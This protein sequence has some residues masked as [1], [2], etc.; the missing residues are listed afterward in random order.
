ELAKILVVM[1][2]EFRNSKSLGGQSPT[3]DGIWPI[4]SL[5]C[6]GFVLRSPTTALK[7]LPFCLPACRQAGNLAQTRN[8]EN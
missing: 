4:S 1:A 8:P 3:P 2:S 5:K 7:I 6:C